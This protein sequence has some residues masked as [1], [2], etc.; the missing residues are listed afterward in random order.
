MIEATATDDSC[1]GP[2]E[3]EEESDDEEVRN[4]PAAAKIMQTG[5]ARGCIEVENVPI[6]IRE[7][8]KAEEQLI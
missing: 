7:L 2:N 3:V 6:D 8:D 4:E 1:T 5:I